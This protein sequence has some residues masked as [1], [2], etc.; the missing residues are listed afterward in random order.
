MPRMHLEIHNLQCHK[1]FRLSFHSSHSLPFFVVYAMNATKSITGEWI[2]F[3][4]GTRH[5]P[6]DE[7]LTRSVTSTFKLIQYRGVARFHF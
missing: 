2:M 4:L 3:H 5:A 1:D 6:P 7:I